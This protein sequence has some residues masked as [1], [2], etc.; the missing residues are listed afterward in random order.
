MTD[1]PERA[2]K[3]TI[4]PPS[5]EPQIDSGRPMVVSVFRRIRNEVLQ[6]EL[7][8]LVAKATTWNEFV[9]AL[10]DGERL[11][12]DYMAALI[13]SENL[14]QLRAAEEA[15]VLAEVKRIFDDEEDRQKDR[16]LHSIRREAELIKAQRELDRLKNHDAGPKE[17]R[18]KRRARR[19]KEIREER[20][21]A[22]KAFMDGREESDLSDEEQQ[23]IADIRLACEH[24]IKRC[25]EED[26]D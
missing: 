7:A 12:Q 14:D 20:D 17:S 10:R 25:L 4:I 26:E 15:K 21:E 19:I 8:S 11:K 3:G 22:I 2:R 16:E 13:R 9:A 1:T 18:G 24:E 23:I 6:K 5:R